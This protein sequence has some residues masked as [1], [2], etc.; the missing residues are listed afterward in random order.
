MAAF[1]YYITRL[2][3]HCSPYNVGNR[4]GLH[5]WKSWCNLRSS[6]SC[7]TTIILVYFD[8]NILYNGWTWSHTVVATQSTFPFNKDNPPIAQQCGT[9]NVYKMTD[10]T[11]N[12]KKVEDK[13]TTQNKK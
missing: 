13:K 5:C 7:P 10:K 6:K 2:H 1:Y 9:V 11:G 3:F 4:L 8:L 12:R